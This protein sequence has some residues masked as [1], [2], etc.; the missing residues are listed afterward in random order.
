VA[1]ADVIAS[2]AGFELTPEMVQRGLREARIPGRMEV[3]QQ[4]PVVILDGAHNPQKMGALTD[5]LQ[6]LY[7]GRRLIVVIGL[8][9]TKDADAM[10]TTLAPLVSH[11]IVTEPHVLGKPSLPAVA[12]AAAIRLPAPGAAIELVERVGLGIECALAQADADTVVLVTGSLY[13][14]GEA[15]NRWVPPEA[16]I[17]GA[18]PPV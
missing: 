5:A 1:A 11:W 10:L 13:M 15:R 8:L 16:L 2:D 9:A 3:I 14:L 17:L 7:P 18:L 12:L 4:D 6:T